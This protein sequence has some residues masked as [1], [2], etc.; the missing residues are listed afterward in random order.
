MTLAER[1]GY[2]REAKL[3]IVNA[4]DFGMC[5]AENTAITQLLQ[6]RAVSSAT[7]M[8]PC[9]WAKE[10]VAWSVANPEFDVGVHLT[11]T[12]EWN[13]YKW[14]RSPGMGTCGHW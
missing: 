6:E 5:H 9:S 10:A 14:G 8:I 12:S 7:V 13:G 2:G 4:D 1:L 11:F 3:L